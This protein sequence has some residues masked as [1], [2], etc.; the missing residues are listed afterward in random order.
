MHNIRIYLKISIIVILAI[1]LTACSQNSPKDSGQVSITQND[2]TEAKN[3]PDTVTSKGIT[4]HQ[5]GENSSYYSFEPGTY[6]LKEDITIEDSIIDIDKSGEYTFDLNGKS[7]SRKGDW[8]G[9]FYFSNGKLTIAGDGKMENDPSVLT[10]ID[11]EATIDSG[12]FN[13]AVS[14]MSEKENTTFT[15]NEAAVNG[16]VWVTG[17]KTEGVIN[18]G[19][20]SGELNA[21]LMVS[22]GAAVTVNDGTFTSGEAALEANK[23]TQNSD[24]GKPAK[25]I[26]ING[27]T[28]KTSVDVQDPDVTP[29]GGIF[30]ESFEKVTLNG[31]TFISEGNA[32]GAIVASVDPANPYDGYKNFLGSGFNYSEELQLQEIK[33]DAKDYFASQS[34]ISVIAEK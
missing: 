25:S 10:L 24:D 12:T 18:N 7:F 9:F 1:L 16:V 20:F 8:S 3:K 19:A 15:V 27:G 33:V 5:E 17:E 28:F 32:L 31:G 14:C 13:G 34:N 21:A 6:K 26:V 4:Y 23:I 29:I 30:L 22:N 11:C 2:F